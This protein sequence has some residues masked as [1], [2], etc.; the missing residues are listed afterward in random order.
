MTPIIERHAAMVYRIAV[1]QLKQPQ[2]AEDVVQEVFLTYLRKPVV[3]Q[4]QD[5]E[6]A[7][8]AKTALH[9]A[10]NVLRLAER[11]HRADGAP[12]ELLPAPNRDETLHAALLSLP[13]DSATLLYL[14]YNERM[15][16][17]LLAEV[18]NISRSLVKKRLVS[19]RR[20]LRAILEVDDHD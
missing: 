1:T 11:R 12:L 6:R 17:A 9:R 18:L 16:I 19:T 10:R 13:E 7:W 15:D 4:N 3:F 5:H 2:D 8:F 14:H 20:Q